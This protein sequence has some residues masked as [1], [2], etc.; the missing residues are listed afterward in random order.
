MYTDIYIYIGTPG[1]TNTSDPNQAFTLQKL[2]QT[3]FNFQYIS[4]YIK[5]C[6]TWH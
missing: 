5:K 1:L 3:L 2:L 6:V 4:V